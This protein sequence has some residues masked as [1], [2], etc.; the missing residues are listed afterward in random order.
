MFSTEVL[1][2]ETRILAFS[3]LLSAELLWIL[4]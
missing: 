2:A 3:E 1:A 4:H